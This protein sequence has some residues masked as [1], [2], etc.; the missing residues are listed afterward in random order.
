LAKQQSS[1]ESYREHRIYDYRDDA[2]LLR[3]CFERSSDGQFAVCQTEFI[4]PGDD[5]P[6]RL[7][8]IAETTTLLLLDPEQPTLW[9]FHSSLKEAIADHDREFA[10]FD[11]WNT[12][13]SN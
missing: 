10:D 5:L 8:Q 4:R 2:L 9:V 3:V 7:A 13:A 1:R 6:M 11:Q 12:D